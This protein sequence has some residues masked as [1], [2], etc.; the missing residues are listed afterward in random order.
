MSLPSKIRG[1]KVL[2]AMSSPLRLQVLNLLFDKG[3]LSYTEL[4]TSLKMN[5]TRDA[6]KFAYHLKFLLKADLVEAD[7]ESKKYVLTELGK[8]VI[9]V[10]D[11]VEKKAI[12]QKGMLVRTS[13]STLETFEANKIADSLIR[14]AKMPVDLAQKTAK[15]AEKLLAKS[16]IKYLTA[17]LVRELVN[18]ILIEKG[19]EDYRHKLTRLGMPVH[20]V[21]ALLE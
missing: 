18:A 2:K 7:V 10:A 15:E 19:L 6:G 1:V 20:E 9:D 4:I 14:E 16:K 21:S 12:K 13:H 5:P 17:P 11:R 8:M 3:S